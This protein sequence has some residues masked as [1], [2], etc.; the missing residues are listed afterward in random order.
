MAD[1][2]RD[3]YYGMSPS[4]VHAATNL[5]LEAFH[6][7]QSHHPYWRGCPA[8]LFMGLADDT[9][10]CLH[11]RIWA[12]CGPS[13]A[14]DFVAALFSCPVQGCPTL[15]SQSPTQSNLQAAA[16][17]AGPHLA[18]QPRRGLVLCARRHQ[19]KHHPQPLG[20]H[21]CR[22]HQR[23]RVG[24]RQGGD[25]GRGPPTAGCPAL[26]DPRPPSPGP[27]GLPNFRI[28]LLIQF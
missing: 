19:E 17:R 12:Q 11:A 2:L 23:L 5:L 10:L 9:M 13:V 25:E 14:H 18:G 22:P 27:W 24:P 3:T 8:A 1:S 20:T 15:S 6:W 16:W 28:P 7:V 4:R 21:G 26:P